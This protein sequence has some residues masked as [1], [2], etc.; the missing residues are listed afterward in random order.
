MTRTVKMEVVADVAWP[1][2]AIAVSVVDRLFE[3]DRRLRGAAIAYGAAANATTS[4][5]LRSAAYAYGVF[6]SAVDRELE[7]TP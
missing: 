1:P 2:P 5:D 6:A 7:V 4:A 3:L